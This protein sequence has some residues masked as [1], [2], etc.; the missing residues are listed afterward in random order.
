[1]YM[2]PAITLVGGHAAYLVFKRHEPF[3]TLNESIPSRKIQSLP[4]NIV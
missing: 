3:D 2:L 4:E 1:M